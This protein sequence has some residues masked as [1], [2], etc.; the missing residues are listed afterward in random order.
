MRRRRADERPPQQ[1]ID[2]ERALLGACFLSMQAIRD[3]KDLV[4]ASDFSSEALRATFQAVLTL[5]EDGIRPDPVSVAAEL[6]KNGIEASL[7]ELSSIQNAVPAISMAKTYAHEVVRTSQVRS[8]QMILAQ[9]VESGYAWDKSGPEYVDSVL[10]SLER[11]DLAPRE[12]THVE[13][14]LPLAAFLAIEDET[15]AQWLI[16]GML[17]ARWRAIF[18]AGEGVGKA[19]LLRQ[20]AIFCSEGLHPFTGDPLPRP[21]VTLYVDG[22]NPADAIKHQSNLSLRDRRLTGTGAAY[23]WSCEAGLDL[24]GR[25]DQS[26]F[27]AAMADVRPDILCLGPLYKMFRKGRDD[28]EDAAAEVAS[29]LDDIRVRYNCAVL[30]EHHAPKGSLSGR[31]LNPFGSSVWMR[32]PELGIKLVV[33]DGQ[34]GVQGYAT[35]LTVGYFRGKR[36]EAT[37]P[38]SLRRGGEQGPPWVGQWPTGTFNNQRPGGPR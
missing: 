22:E 14:V 32:W 1:A 35:D 20:I 25:R 6:A 28:H 9:S 11:V 38:V 12:V 15:P 5:Y 37:W 7:E 19:V 23:I 31:E 16:P 4:M 27:E 30:I 21:L 33:E 3:V 8:A 17:R 34:I 2:S 13:E 29:F 18:V 36:V 26:K 10:Q 24:R